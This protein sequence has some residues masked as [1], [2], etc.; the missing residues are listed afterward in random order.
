MKAWK[1]GWLDGYRRGWEYGY[2]MG[3]CEAII[4]SNLPGEGKRWD[5]KVLFVPAQGAPYASLDQGIGK[6][7]KRLVREAVIADSGQDPVVLAAEH[8]PDLV[9][10]LDA[11]GK[12]FPAGKA[13]ELRKMGIRTAVW[14]PDDPYH[15]DTTLGIAPHYEYVFTIEKSC[16]PYYR[17]LGISQVH[18]L[19]LAVNP[20]VVRPTYAETSYETDVCF[21]GSAFW[22]RVALFDEIAPSLAGKKVKIVGYWW[23]RLKNVDMLKDS[24]HGVWLSPEETIKYYGRAKI[25]LNIHRSADDPSHNSNSRNIPAHSVNPRMFEISACGTLQLADIRDGLPEHYEPDHDIATFSSVDEL[26]KKIDYYLRHEDE[27][28]EMAWRGLAKTMRDHTFSNR[29]S[30]LLGI[31]F[32]S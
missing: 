10:V 29:L 2:H 24:I 28:R 25:V 11:L 21:I 32:G 26:A 1:R 16:V 12:T 18:Y 22:N 13:A 17:E 20:D 31:V 23:E 6:E 3:K 15:S 19:P 4:Q 14:L 8:R 30:E 7:L 27:R 9:L 5:V